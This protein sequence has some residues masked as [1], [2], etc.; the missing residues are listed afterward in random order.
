VTVCGDVE[1]HWSAHDSFVVPSWMPHRH[2]N[3]SGSDAVLFSA[4]DQPLLAAL[5]LYRE[6]PERASYLRPAPI[7][8]GNRP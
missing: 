7:A 8:P 5:N 3:A 1:L 6:E 2:V 4:T